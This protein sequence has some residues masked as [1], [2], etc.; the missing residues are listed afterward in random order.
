MIKD[1]LCE[2]YLNML[3]N[4]DNLISDAPDLLQ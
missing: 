4:T 2:S 1:G 3:V